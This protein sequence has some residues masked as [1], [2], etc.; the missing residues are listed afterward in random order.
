MPAPHRVVI[1]AFPGVELLDITGPAEVFSVA[2][3]V[4]D[5]GHPGYTVQIATADGGAVTTSSGVRLLADLRL[6]EVTG[7]VDT[8]LVSGAVTRPEGG[9]ARAVVDPVVTDWLRTAVPRAGRTGS[10][11]AGAHL[12]AAAGLLDGRSATT[13]WLTAAQLTA[14]H[15]EIS[16]DPDA[17]FIRS[18]SLWTCAGVTTGMDMALAMVAEDHGH[19][20]ALATARMM[21]M[22]VK[23]SGGQSQF[24][25]LLSVQEPTCD[26]LGELRQWITEHPEADLSAEALAQR[27]SLSTRHFSRLFAQRTG[28]TPAAYVESARLETARR[29]LEES[30]TGLPQIAVTSGLGSLQTL[31]RAFQRHLGTTP[32]EYRRRFR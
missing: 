1:V 17:I 7:R 6:D 14:A 25:V 23:R 16:V 22:Y 10:V 5:D 26:R 11:C 31:H 3:R 24:S 27:V 32:A 21:V 19:A 30:D 18:G 28:T 13:H 9:G 2:S 15:P 29:L 12:L 20:L 4:A 8:L